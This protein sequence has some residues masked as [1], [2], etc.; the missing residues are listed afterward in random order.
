MPRGNAHFSGKMN[1]FSLFGM[2]YAYNVFPINGT[3]PLF[4]EGF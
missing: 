2:I 3:K 1:G 4:Q